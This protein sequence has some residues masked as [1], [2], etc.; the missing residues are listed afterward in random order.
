MLSIML[1]ACKKLVWEGNS[2]GNRLEVRIKFLQA[3]YCL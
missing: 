2:T 3:L 1:G